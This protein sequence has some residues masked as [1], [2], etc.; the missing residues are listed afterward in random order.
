L[1]A[2]RSIR[3]SNA[4]SKILNRSASLKISWSVAQTA[5][6]AAND[7]DRKLYP[8]FSPYLRIQW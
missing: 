2:T 3:K 6:I 7:P 8:E 5:L 4:C 1:I